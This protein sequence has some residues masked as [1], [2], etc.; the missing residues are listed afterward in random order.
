MDKKYE[1]NY[2]KINEFH[3]DKNYIRLINELKRL[4]VL[5]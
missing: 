5:R 4:G 2:K 1:D 3:D